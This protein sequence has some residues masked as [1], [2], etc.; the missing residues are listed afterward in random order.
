MDEL[1]E[2]NRRW[3]TEKTATDPDFFRRLSRTQ[4]PAYLWIGCSDSRVPANEILGLDPGE[5]FVHRNVANLVVASDTNLLAV[6]QYGVAVLGVRDVL[7]AGHYGCGGV[8][9]AMKGHSGLGFVDAWLQPLTGLYAAHRA[10]LD[11]I[12]DGDARADRLCELNVAAQVDNL[13]AT[14]MVQDAWA[15][16]QPLNLHG[17]IYS[18]ADGRLRDLGCTRSGPVAAAP[19]AAVRHG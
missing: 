5:V 18:L 12:P 15:R 17:L 19:A 11:A 6:L 1:F 8:R 9:A 3:R 16:G 13:A 2:N 4:A 14:T 10:E 7:V